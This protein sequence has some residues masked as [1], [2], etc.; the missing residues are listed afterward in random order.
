MSTPLDLPDGVKPV[1]RAVLLRIARRITEGRFD[2]EIH[3]ITGQGSV[4]SIRWIQSASGA[5]RK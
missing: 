4:R 1:L 2:G 3:I 5:A